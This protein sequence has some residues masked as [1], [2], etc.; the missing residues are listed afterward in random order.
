MRQ[1]LKV[2]TKCT[3]CLLTRFLESALVLILVKV[4]FIKVHTNHSVFSAYNKYYSINF[5]REKISRQD[6][7]FD[8]NFN[9]LLKEMFTSKPHKEY[10]EEEV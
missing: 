7:I 5:L 2:D 1:F 8:S 10:R 3:D 6:F 9:E 4:A